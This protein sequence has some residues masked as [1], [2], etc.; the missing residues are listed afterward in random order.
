MSGWT[1]FCLVALAIQVNQPVVAFVAI[2]AYF[3]GD[4]PRQLCAALEKRIKKLE[5]GQ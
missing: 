5:G 4:T 2:M 3:A 1:A